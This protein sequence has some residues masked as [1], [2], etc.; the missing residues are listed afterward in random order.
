MR[1]R[2]FY[3]GLT[4]ELRVAFAQQVGASEGYLWQIATRWRRRRPSI[5]LM[6]KLCK[7]EKKLKL[8]DLMDE[9]ADD[10]TP[11]TQLEAS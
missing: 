4:P 8:K 2:D 9:F 7:A 5:D 11:T 1:F 3:T 10:S 6:A